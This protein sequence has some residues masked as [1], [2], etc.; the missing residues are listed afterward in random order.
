MDLD[1]EWRQDATM[2]FRSRVALL[3]VFAA[4]AG[5]AQSNS[6][7][8]TQGNQDIGQ[9]SSVQALR[10][11]DLVG[12][13]Q[14]DQK[15]VEGRFDSATD[16]RITLRAISGKDPEITLEKANVVRVYR[17][18]HH[19][20]VFGAVVGGAVGIAA[21]ALADATVGQYFRNETGG[22][23]KGAITAV[24]GAAGAGIGAAV[25]GG[26]QTVYRRPK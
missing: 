1:V 3:L 19:R 14:T 24:G 22:T 16:A 4:Q 11:G 8:N 15:R 10:N 5:F 26:Y 6:Q 7:R 12:V 18:A 21:G 23:P 13:I 20:R 17:K 2:K 9:W 25:S